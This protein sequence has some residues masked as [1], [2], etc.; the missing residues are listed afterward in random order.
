MEN[1][2]KFIKIVNLFFYASMSVTDISPLHLYGPCA[3]VHP[4]YS[5]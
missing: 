3:M 5:G 4:D 1:L 2:P